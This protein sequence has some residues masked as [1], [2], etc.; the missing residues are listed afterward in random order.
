MPG[1]HCKSVVLARSGAVFRRFSGKSSQCFHLSAVAR[2]AT[3]NTVS[4][5]P[6]YLDRR[7]SHV[8]SHRRAG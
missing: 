5:S 2:T 8:E 7:L 3:E 6:V 1:Y 4:A